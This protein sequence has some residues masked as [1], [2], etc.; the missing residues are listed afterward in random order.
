MHMVTYHNLV[1]VRSPVTWGVIPGWA[2]TI[3]SINVMTPGLIYE[4]LLIYL[5]ESLPLVLHGLLW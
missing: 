2:E 5:P 3:C 1:W 4:G